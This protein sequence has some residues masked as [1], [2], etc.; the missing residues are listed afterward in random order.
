[1]NLDRL[2]VLLRAEFGTVSYLSF[3]M[4]LRRERHFKTGHHLK[5]LKDIFKY[6]VLT[7]SS[8]FVFMH[9]NQML[10]YVQSRHILK[11]GDIL[12]FLSTAC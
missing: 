2:T 9:Q 3:Y 12:L 8:H 4:Y 7:N 11:K 5:F 10:S 6:T 1:M